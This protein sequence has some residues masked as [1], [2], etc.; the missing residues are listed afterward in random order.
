MVAHPV[1]L[2]GLGFDGRTGDP[3]PAEGGR[4]VLVERTDDDFV[5]ALLAELATA[6]GRKAIAKATRSAGEPVTSLSLLQPV[7]R[8][9]YL[10]VFEVVCEVFGEPRLDPKQIDSAGLVLR[11]VNKSGAREGWMRKNGQAIGWVEL[12]PEELDRDPD[13]ARRKSPH[14]AGNAEIEARLASTLGAPDPLEE[15]TTLL[16]V[17]PPNVCAAVGK[18][19]LY[20]LVPLASSEFARTNLA[21]PNYDEGEIRDMLSPYFV[22]SP[23]AP[24]LRGLAGKTFTRKWR[25]ELAEDKTFLAEAGGDK[26]LAETLRN[27]AVATLERFVIMLRGLSA[28]FDAFENPSMKKALDGV[29]LPYKGEAKGR[30]A[31]KTLADAAEVF[32]HD[33][34]NQ[35]F[36]MP[37][38][39]PA[40]TQAQAATIAAAAS[41]ASQKRVAAIAPRRGRF[42]DIDATYEIQAFVRVKRDDGCPPKLSFCAAPSRAFRVAPWYENGNLPPI[43]V[44]LPP[45]DKDNIKKFLPN[46]AFRVPKNIFDMLAKNKP[47]DFLDGKAKEGAGGIDWICGFN[48]PIITLCAFL[49]LNIFIGL[50]NIVFFWIAFIKICIPVPKSLTQ[51]LP[52]GMTS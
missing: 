4:P 45:I 43:Q 27:T 26:A 22:V 20:G 6:E 15:A 1:S 23:S 29:L 25:E 39:W 38:S 40:I 7:H 33:K 13:P 31:G 17:A 10:A 19:I 48:I 52:K 12:G 28:V 51:G 11:R 44:A 2:R 3:L 49:V 36:V 50:F 42:D 34:R 18:T 35:S 46:V 14:A 24:S 41:L 30:P 47:E 8:S 21:P 9:F 16:F 32:V 37:A 5:V